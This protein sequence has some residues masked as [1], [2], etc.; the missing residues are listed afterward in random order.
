MS[1][2]GVQHG[3]HDKPLDWDQR[4]TRVSDKTITKNYNNKILPI[5]LAIRGVGELGQ[6]ALVHVAPGVQMELAGSF[7][8]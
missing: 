4:L 3:G 6:V 1:T 7:L 5:L 8:G 2:D